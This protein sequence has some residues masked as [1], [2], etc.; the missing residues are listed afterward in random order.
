MNLIIEFTILIL[1]SL[2]IYTAKKIKK[3]DLLLLATLFAVIFENIHAVIF[4][5]IEGGYFYDTS[6]L[7][8]YKTPLFVILAWGM[9]IFI[10]YL[11]ATKLTKTKLQRLFLTPLLAV[12]I[13]FAIDPFAVKIGYWTWIGYLPT[14]GFFGV[15]ALNFIAWYLVTL[16]FLTTYEYLPIK[17]KII[18]YISIIP[19]SYIIF[20]IIM[21][22]LVIPRAL[23]NFQK[24][25]DI[26]A[27]IIFFIIT[28]LLF[29]YT[30]KKKTQR[31][32]KDF[33]QKTIVHA[34]ILRWI[35][36]LFA[37]I[38]IVMLWDTLSPTLVIVTTG[39]MLVELGLSLYTLKN[40]K[41]L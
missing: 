27:L 10:S 19:I 17:N 9:I 34:I 2:T 28:I 5:N 33:K 14:E 15:P 39:F 16:S 37:I 30:L 29:I 20:A 4:K 3:L 31:H 40:A 32:R 18:K 21:N 22:L 6:F 38:L 25:Y 41:V 24:E 23:L 7:L 12:L 26:Y 36:Y 1:Y 13:D 8:I 11:I 35:F